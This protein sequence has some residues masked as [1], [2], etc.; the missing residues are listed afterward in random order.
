MS[1]EFSADQMLPKAQAEA[2][3]LFESREDF[4]KAMHEARE[5]LIS[6]AYHP[7][8]N[9]H[10]QNLGIAAGSGFVLG[11]A[12]TA[13]GEVLITKAVEPIARVTNAAIFSA[14]GGG[15][16][17]SELLQRPG[18]RAIECITPRHLLIGGLIGAGLATAAYEGYRFLRAK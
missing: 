9:Q 17:A 13:G 18:L 3:D 16:V 15:R 12:A 10:L 7:Q 1:N 8:A 5:A 2:M 14:L 6:Q 11:G 4:D